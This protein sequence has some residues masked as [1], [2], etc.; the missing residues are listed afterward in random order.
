VA[1]RWS[2]KNSDACVHGQP[3]G[4]SSPFDPIELATPGVLQN[5]QKRASIVGAAT[6]KIKGKKMCDIKLT[7]LDHEL[8]LA[9]VAECASQRFL[10]RKV[11][12]AWEDSDLRAMLRVH[13]AE[14]SRQIKRLAR[15][16]ESVSADSLPRIQDSPGIIPSGELDAESERQE[17]A[18]YDRLLR[19]CED[20]DA[21]WVV[22][23]LEASRL[24]EAQMARWIEA[25][26]SPAN[27]NKPRQ[28]ADDL[29]IPSET[30]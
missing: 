26:R 14:T 12:E 1:F 9:Y 25:Y 11:D 7:K 30:S 10:M 13:L 6:L 16:I 23:V 4:S 17:V 22:P 5:E 19:K 2:I 29:P 28:L 15:C 3:G 20:A 18:M 24:E 27:E 8:R 21:H